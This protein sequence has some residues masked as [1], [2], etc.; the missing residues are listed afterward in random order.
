VSLRNNS[1]RPS[2]FVSGFFL[3]IIAFLASNYIN[4]VFPAS[5]GHRFF[6]CQT[7]AS[8]VITSK[9]TVTAWHFVIYTDATFAIRAVLLTFITNSRFTQTV[10]RE[11]NANVKGFNYRLRIRTH[12]SKFEIPFFSCMMLDL[13]AD[14]RCLYTAFFRIESNVHKSQDAGVNLRPGSRKKKLGETK[15]GLAQLDKWHIC[16]QEL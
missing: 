9:V 15:A 4:L 6:A 16:L 11:G 10:L 8:G 5:I 3:H 14:S 1:L 2:H 12:N 7:Y 13:D